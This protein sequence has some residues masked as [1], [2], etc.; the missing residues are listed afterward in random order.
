M[1]GIDK[2][3]VIRWEVHPK[4]VTYIAMETNCTIELE[5]YMPELHVASR[6]MSGWEGLGQGNFKKKAHVHNDEGGGGK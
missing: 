2:L 6:D 4:N 1:K 5:P 3:K